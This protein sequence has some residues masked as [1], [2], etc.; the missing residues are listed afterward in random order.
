MH[1]NYRIKLTSSLPIT[2]IKKNIVLIF[3][4]IYLC[5]GLFIYSDYGISWDEPYQ[6]QIGYVNFTY[7]TGADRNALFN[8]A[9]KYYGAAFELP[10]VIV[11]RAFNIQDTKTIYEVR[12]LFTFL[13]FYVSVIFFYKL[14]MLIFEDQRYAV[15]SSALLTLSP[16]IFADSFYNS[17]DIPLLA[18]FIITTYTL[19]QL[20]RKKT[21]KWTI[22]HALAS[23]FLIDIRIVG[24]ILP[25]F[26]FISMVLLI[27]KKEFQ[28]HLLFLYIAVFTIAVI[29]FWPLLWSNPLAIF[30]SF[31]MMANYHFQTNLPVLY[32]GEFIS[33][34]SLP[35]HYIPT[36]ISS[37]TPLSYGILFIIGSI[38]TFKNL[39]SEKA[40]N[41][42]F[43]QK[44]IFNLITLL[45]I[46]L[47]VISVI[48]LQSTLYDGWRH[49][50]F[51]YPFMVIV[52]VHGL[53]LAPKILVVLTLLEI[54]SVT[55]FMWQQHPYQNLYFN[56]LLSN[57]MEQVK[58]N[59]ELD[60][61]G[62]SYRDALEYIV[63]NDQ[64]EKISLVVA[65][66]P[67]NSN[68]L[69]LNEADKNR[70]VYLS[71]DK[72]ENADYFIT[73][74]RWHPSPYPYENEIFTITLDSAKIIS[75]F[76]L[77]D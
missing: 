54:T 68:S 65:N 56:S 41:K 26:T 70:L 58:Q 20:L 31:K 60:Y 3:F 35:W 46:F 55:L 52:M 47:P 57:N 66:N 74:Y 33:P 16:R 50:Y 14:A 42:I 15:V 17:K 77:K 5:I 2:L 62:L 36:W 38:T 30:E 29:V 37:T 25:I 61:W 44:N 9:D 39:V 22:I 63:Q 34:F 40:I 21:L 53:K 49:L 71:D 43:E 45:L 7:V 23:A 67:G 18:L 8:S 12:H 19:F 11:E 4:S 73:N 32:R 27:W 10:L 59:Y 76:K 51:I 13:I 48:L 64:S 24:I 72:I 75:V 1:K 28:P 6:R 69:M